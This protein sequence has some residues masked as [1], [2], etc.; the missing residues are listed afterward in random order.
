MT[1]LFEI[2]PG[3]QYL[4]TEELGML[5]NSKLPS[6]QCRWLEDNGWH[7]ERSRGGKPI[8]SRLYSQLRGLGINPK[9]FMASAGQLPDFSKLR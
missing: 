6:I 5:A 3:E 2:P 4:T 9:T 8:V 1:A 7:F